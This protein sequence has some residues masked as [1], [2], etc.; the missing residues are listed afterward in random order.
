MRAWTA[1]VDEKVVGWANARLR[2]SLEA[3]DV[4][5]GWVGVLPAHRQRGL[6]SALYG[7]AEDH[8]RQ[9]GA[10]RFMS[11]AIESDRSGRA[12]AARRG[13][14]EGRRDQSWELDVAKAGLR[15]P[16][17]PPGAAIVRLRSVRD[18]ERD[19]FELYDAAHTDM[20][21]DDPYTLEFDEWLSETLGDPTLDLDV[22]AVVLVEDR[23]AAFAWVNSDREGGSGENEMTGTHPDFRRRGLARLAKEASILWAAEAGIR[24]LFTA[25]DTTNADMLALNEHLGYRPTHVQL[26]LTKDLH[27]GEPGP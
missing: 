19:L 24:T 22:S 11:F 12:F 21:G 14:R 6:G 27:G 5:G 18:R 25:N 2:W 3:D 10:R 4:A 7:L 15:R 26:E 8:A 23:P 20:P 1:F 17:P 16:G 13:F 9:L